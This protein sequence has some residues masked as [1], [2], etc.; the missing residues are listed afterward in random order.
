MPF[1]VLFKN[2]KGQS[3][4][5]YD[6]D[7]TFEIVEGGVLKIALKRTDLVSNYF[8]PDYWVEVASHGEL[9]TPTLGPPAP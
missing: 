7:H 5:T 6:D 4:R 9:V 3:E 2:P 8:A 1:T